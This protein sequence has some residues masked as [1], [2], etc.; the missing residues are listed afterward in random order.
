MVALLLKL[1][2][3]DLV[4]CNGSC[5]KMLTQSERKPQKKKDKIYYRKWCITCWN[6]HSKVSPDP[7]ITEKRL[8]NKKKISNKWRSQNRDHFNEKQKL[9]TSIDPNFAQRRRDASK[10]SRTKPESRV[11]RLIRE[12]EYYGINAGKRL[13]H[14]KAQHALHK[15][16]G[17][18]DYMY[19]MLEKFGFKVDNMHGKN[20]K[21]LCNNCW[22]EDHII[23]RSKFNFEILEEVQ[24][25]WSLWNVRPYLHSLN[26]SEQDRPRIFGQFSSYR[27]IINKVR[28]RNGF[29]KY[30]YIT[31]LRMVANAVIENHKTW[32]EVISN[33][34]MGIRYDTWRP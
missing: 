14:R 33:L 10:K 23:P 27:D 30:D 2:M 28:T 21:G 4:L 16:P 11:R 22:S 15:I 13:V 3:S 29:S 25:C 32:E 20:C 5:G 26:I 7:I 1:S 24:L 12:R 19:M 8:V 6:R 18:K 34:N 31:I 9:K 17:Y